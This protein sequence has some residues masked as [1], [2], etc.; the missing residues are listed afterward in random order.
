MIP[1]LVAFFIALIPTLTYQWPFTFDIFVHIQIAQVYSHYGFTLIDPLIDPP[2]GTPIGYPPLFSYLLLFLHSI[3]K[4]DYFNVARILQ[5][6]FATS[7]VISTSYVAKKYY[8]DIAGI[9]AGFLILSSFLFG[10]LI[11][12]LPETIA[13][14]IVPLVV[15]AYYCSIKY[16]KYKYSILA[17]FLFLLIILTHQATTLLIFLII[18]SI[19][20]ILGILRR[21]TKFF[22]NYALFL[23]IPLLTALIVFITVLIV[24]P[25][26][27]DKI[28][29]YGF[30]AI[31]G[32]TAS[33]PTNEPISDLKY[34]AYLGIV[35]IFAIIGAFLA[36]KRR[37]NKDLF[38]IIWILVIFIMSKSYWFGVNVYTLRLLIH[39]LLPLSILGGMGLSY[40]YLDFKKGIFTS[41]PIRS[42]FLIAIFVISSFFALS[43]VLDPKFPN[44]PKYDLSNGTVSN[45]QIVPPSTS[46]LDMANWFNENGNKSKS[47]L[48]T[49]IYSGKILLALTGQPIATI[50]A[51][52]PYYLDGTKTTF[53]L[54]RNIQNSSIGYLVYDK[55]LRFNSQN[56]TS[57]VDYQNFIYYSTDIHKII[58]PYAHIVHENDN[59]IICKVD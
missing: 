45:P 25:S 8:G 58:P 33:L 34:V 40:I 18:T 5:P 51:T 3:L 13:L 49:N 29:T 31:T 2:V 16:N 38:V 41:K 7:V 36:F 4:I 35:L 48:I 44:I 39:L 42:G 22:T 56:S 27:V 53:I 28:Y 47:V 30:S 57:L 52:A 6:I 23:S 54:T 50:N 59:Y 1:G 43:I 26:F 24:S 32:Y 46:D 10:R 11:T 19:A 17:S 20:I 12:P 37:K 14:I 21:E 15:Y 55:R 9:S